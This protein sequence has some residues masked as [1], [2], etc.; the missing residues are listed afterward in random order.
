LRIVQVYPELEEGRPFGAGDAQFAGLVRAAIGP[1]MVDGQ[2]AADVGSE[3]QD[4]RGA[5]LGD[6]VR[7]VP[8]VRACTP[9]GRPEVAEKSR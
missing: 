2:H 4:R 7:R 5:G 1:V 3:V 8:K 6:V 9:L